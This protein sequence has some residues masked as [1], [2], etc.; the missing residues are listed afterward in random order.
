MRRNDETR[1]LLAGLSYYTG[2]RLPAPLAEVARAHG[3]TVPGWMYPVPFPSQTEGHAESTPA[4]LL[5]LGDSLRQRAADA[6]ITLL[7]P[8]Q[9]GWPAGPG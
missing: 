7:V 9:A 4:D 3:L 2:R 6:G 5:T 1:S 8:G